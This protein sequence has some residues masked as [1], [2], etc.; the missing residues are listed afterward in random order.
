MRS[1]FFNYSTQATI[2]L[3]QIDS[4]VSDK[5]CFYL[6]F[7]LET[8]KFLD[9]FSVWC[10][11][12]C[13]LVSM[14]GWSFLSWSFSSLPDLFCYGLIKYKKFIVF[15]IMTCIMVW[16]WYIL[17]K[18]SWLLRKICI[19]KLLDGIFCRCLLTLVYL[20]N[21]LLIFFKCRPDYG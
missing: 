13:C 6:Y 16:M 17:E 11:G 21:Y 19:S 18:I 1:F 8:S 15:D 5:L 10:S 4:K 7:I 14:C 20:L 2:E 3:V 12:L 9:F